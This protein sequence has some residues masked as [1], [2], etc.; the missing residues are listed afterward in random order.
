MP[1][2]LSGAVLA[3][4]TLPVLAGA[5]PSAQVLLQ[6]AD[7]FR[8]PDADLEIATSVEIV[9]EGGAV[10]NRRDYTVFSQRDRRTLV[11][12]TNGA[13]KGQKI[14]MLGSDFWLFLPTSRRPLRIT[15][16]QKLLGDASTGDIAT[17]RW[18]TE[19]TAEILGEETFEGRPSVRLA[20]QANASGATYD[21]IELWL[22][23]QR[24]EP[25]KADYYMQSSKLAK[26]ARFV[27]DETPGTPGVRE[28]LIE[29]HLR[30]KRA[31]RVRYL[32]RVART[33]PAAWMNP[34]FLS[35][36]PDLGQ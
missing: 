35:A 4:L 19:Y 23:R 7:Q 17:M 3:L 20:L 30:G 29:D 15:A 16:M 1:K 34:M 24:G 5:L 31:T 22:G 6:R 14:L 8:A 12:M 28:M 36:N 27:V 21:R 33:I 10:E 9:A 18:S 26:K 13:E 32:S 11:L 25:L 2:L